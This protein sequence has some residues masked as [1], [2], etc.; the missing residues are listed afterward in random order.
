MENFMKINGKEQADYVM[1]NGTYTAEDIK[2]LGDLEA[3]LRRPA[4]Y[5]GTTDLPG[6][7][8]LVYEVVDNSIDESQAGFCKNIEI[9]IHMDNS[10]TV[11]DDGRGIPVD[12]HPELKKP[13]AEIVLTKLHAG[14]KFGNDAY[15]VSG[16]WH[17]VGNIDTDPLFARRG[18]WDE[19]GTPDD[20]YDDIWVEG[21]YHLKSQ[22]GRWDPVSR[23]WVQ[24]DVTSPCIDAGDPNSP[25]GLEPFPNGGRINMGAY[26]GTAQ[27]SKSYFGQPN[28]QTIVAGDINGDCKVDWQD[29]AILASHWLGQY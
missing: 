3:V 22:A 8:H 29:L 14:G 10:V 13:A 24:D 17:G 6:L 25:V 20:P 16:G 18:Y 2:V 28:C 21:D 27:A 4:M 23:S 1:E 5:I 26:G 12:I 7:H 15:K 9:I 11:I 19:N